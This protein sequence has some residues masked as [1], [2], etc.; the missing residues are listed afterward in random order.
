MVLK[1]SLGDMVL[2]AK[3]EKQVLL[4][5]LAFMESVQ[6]LVEDQVALVALGQMDREAMMQPK[7]AMS[8]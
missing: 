7:Q 3:L 8:F 6:V 4:D 2:L 1:P 5:F